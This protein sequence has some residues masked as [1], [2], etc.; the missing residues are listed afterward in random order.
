MDWSYSYQIREEKGEN[1]L[2]KL[3]RWR[4]RDGMDVQQARLIKDRVGNVLTGA[5]G[6]MGR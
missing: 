1:D 4:N 6:V 3:A 5:R 2:Y